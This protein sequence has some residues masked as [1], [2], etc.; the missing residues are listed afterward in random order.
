MI[1]AKG[2]DNMARGDAGSLHFK[3]EQNGTGGFRRPGAV[4]ELECRKNAYISGQTHVNGIF[5][6]SFRHLLGGWQ[7]CRLMVAG[8]PPDTLAAR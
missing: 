2:E 3:G 7:T 5:L 4:T 6:I 1:E 8:D